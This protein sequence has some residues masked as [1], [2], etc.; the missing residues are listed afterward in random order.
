MTQLSAFEADDALA[1]D[2]R[3]G[4]RAGSDLVARQAN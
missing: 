3:G 4:L 1:G 2:V